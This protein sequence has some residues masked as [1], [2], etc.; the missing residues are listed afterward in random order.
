MKQKAR[1]FSSATPVK[2]HGPMMNPKISAVPVKAALVEVGALTLFSSG[3]YIPVRAAEKLW[4]LL[5]DN[6]KIGGGC[7]N[8]YK[9]RDAKKMRE[10]EKN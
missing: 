6:D 4:S 3:V 5:R 8:I 7:E 10:S 1:V 2:I 9:L